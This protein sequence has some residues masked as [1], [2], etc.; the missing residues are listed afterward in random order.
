MVEPFAETPQR[1]ESTASSASGCSRVP[2]LRVS[3]AMLSTPARF[4]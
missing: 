4:G 2:S 3:S 1:A